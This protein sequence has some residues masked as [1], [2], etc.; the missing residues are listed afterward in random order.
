MILDRLDPLPE[1]FE[2]GT[3]WT[4]KPEGAC[5]GEIC[6]PLGN[7]PGPTVDVPAVAERLGMPLVHDPQAAVWALGPETLAGRA[8]S[9]VEVPEITLEGLDG[10]PFELARLRG[11]KI[12]V[13]AWAP[14]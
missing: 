2:A 1:T 11:Q 5:K 7:P 3:G 6:V 9:T 13:Y 14:Y 10:T 4:L 12:L 8:L